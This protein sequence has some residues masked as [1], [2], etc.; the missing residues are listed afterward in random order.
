MPVLVT[1]G[2]GFI[3]SHIAEYFASRGREVVLITR[4]HTRLKR[5]DKP[6]RFK[7]AIGNLQDSGFIENLFAQY[8]PSV[9]IHAAWEGLGHSRLDSTEQS[10]NLLSIESLLKAS[11]QVGVDTFIGLGSQAEYGVYNRRIDENTWPRPTVRYGVYK[12]A[13]GLLGQKYASQCGMRFAW[14]R[15]F[16]IFGPRDHDSC[17]LPGVISSLLRNEVP[18]LTGCEQTWEYLYVKDVPRLLAKVIDTE[19]RFCGIY[20]LCSG[21]AVKLKDV[22]ETISEIIQSSVRPDFGALPYREYGLSHLEGDNNLFRDI[23]GWDELTDL[24]LA[25]EETVAWHRDRL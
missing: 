19:S 13:A 3:G 18:R 20:N 16:S 2:T 11:T 6:E 1:G 21:E 5:L 9:V 14:L 10:N 12:L 25:L 15:V 17:L 24:R 8:R 7:C 4:D 23:F 22:V